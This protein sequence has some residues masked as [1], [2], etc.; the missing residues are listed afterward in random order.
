MHRKYTH[1][2]W[3]NGAL[4]R[5]FPGLL[6]PAIPPKTV[7][8][9]INLTEQTSIIREKRYKQLEEFLNKIKDHP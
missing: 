6:I 9:K 2:E 5:E 1:F 3:L 7:L 8:A 4:K